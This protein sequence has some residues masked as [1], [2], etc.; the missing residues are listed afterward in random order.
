MI[1]G[2]QKKLLLYLFNHCQNIG[3]RETPLF[4]L[5]E[6]SS[7]LDCSNHSLK[8]SIRQLR[9]KGALVKTAFK[10]DNRHPFPSAC[11]TKKENRNSLKSSICFSVSDLY[12]GNIE[13][14][15][16]GKWQESA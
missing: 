10:D 8:S 14:F 2:L 6:L 16:E 3:A 12:E 9:I 7:A 4:N 15:G 5:N 1:I 13:S 11:S